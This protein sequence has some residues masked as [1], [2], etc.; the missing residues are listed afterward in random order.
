[1]S[2]PPQ[3][4]A[5]EKSKS[6]AQANTKTIPHTAKQIEAVGFSLGIDTGIRAV[7]VKKNEGKYKHRITCE[8][9]FMQKKASKSSGQHGEA[10]RA[11]GALGECFSSL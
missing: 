10:A 2:M 4:S 5:P 9:N 1:M 7:Q 11:L 6:A 3:R 8:N